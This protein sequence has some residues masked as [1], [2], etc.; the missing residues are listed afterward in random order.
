MTAYLGGKH[1]QGPAIA[2]WVSKLR[3]GRT[4]YVEPF[5][6]MMGSA[7]AV[8]LRCP[9]MELD[10]SDANAYVIRMWEALLLEGWD[11][12]TE[13]AWETYWQ[14]RRAVERKD[15]AALSDP[16][17][18]YIGFGFT[19]SAKFFATPARVARGVNEL[20]RGSG[21]R[22]ACIRKRDAL[23]AARSV[24]IGCRD[25]REARE[26]RDAVIYLD[27]PYFGRVRQTAGLEAKEDE[28]FAYCEAMAEH[29]LGNVVL[30]SAFE[31]YEGTVVLHDWG[32]TIAQANVLEENR[33]REYLMRVL[34]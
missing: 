11:P 21:P 18:A 24:S 23:L 14:Y 25:Y 34:P 9:D 22:G 5:C 8:A 26:Y 2:E 33:A 30:T 10:L 3:D 16:L 1:R 29:R 17:T 12:P 6:G 13:V 19:F 28:F 32:D 20:K 7:S 15:P 31:V 27:P 4:Q